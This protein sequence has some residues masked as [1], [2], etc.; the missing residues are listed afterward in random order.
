MAN[1]KPEA[2]KLLIFSGEAEEYAPTVA[3]RCPDLDVVVC[4]DYD[5]LGNALATERPSYVLTT[6]FK[7][8][9]FPR[10]VLFAAPSVQ[11]V[12]VPGARGWAPYGT[13]VSR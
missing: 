2:E 3:M 10:E 6:T 5:D 8:R 1:R 13:S 12:P 4:R 7:G 9:V 11:G